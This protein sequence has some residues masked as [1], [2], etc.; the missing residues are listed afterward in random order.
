MEPTMPD[1]TDPL[2]LKHVSQAARHERLRQTAGMP[3]IAATGRH[4]G[5]PSSG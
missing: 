2:F 4:S 1:P 3:A 5:R